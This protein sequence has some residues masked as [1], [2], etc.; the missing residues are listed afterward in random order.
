MHCSRQQDTVLFQILCHLWSNNSEK[1]NSKESIR[2][3]L[4]AWSHALPSFISL[5]F[6]DIG[7][8]TLTQEDLWNSSQQQGRPPYIG[9][10]FWKIVS[11]PDKQW[12]IVEGKQHNSIAGS[13]GN[14]FMLLKCMLPCA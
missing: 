1:N 2:K 8:K 6:T 4:E 10:K 11:F 14:I 12:S 7:E 9:T 13:F 5:H 3:G